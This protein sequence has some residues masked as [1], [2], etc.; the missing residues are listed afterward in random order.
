MKSSSTNVKYSVIIGY[1]LVV[2]VMIIGIV[3][4]YRNLV[5]FSEKKI[6]DEDLSE[7]LIVGNAISK[8]YDIESSQNLFNVSSAEKYFSKYDSILPLVK[9]NIDTL[10]HLAKTNSRIVKLD[11]IELL[12]ERKNKNLKEIV[13]LLDSIQKA[14]RITRSVENKIVPKELNTQIVDYLQSRN[15]NVE[16]DSVQTDTTVVYG[17]R[18]RFLDRVRDVFVARTDSTVMVDR[19]TTILPMTEFKLVVDTVVNM[20]RYSERV[21]LENQRKFQYILLQRQNAMAATNAQLTQQIDELLTG[22]EQEELAKSLQLVRDRDNAIS[23]S[24]QVVYL[25]ILLASLIVLIFGILYIADF[26]RSQRYRRQLEVSN[27]RISGLLKS[28]EQLILAVSHDIKAPMSS[29]IGYTELMQ[30]ELSSDKQKEYLKNMKNSGEH[31]LQ[32]TANLLDYHKLKSGTMIVQE[33][34]V[35]IY[36]LAESIINSFSPIAQ[37]KNIKYIT[38]NKLNKNLVGRIDSYIVRQIMNNIISNAIKY[39]FDGNVQVSVSDKRKNDTSW[40]VFSVKD[41]GIGIGKENQQVIFEEFRQLTESD[42]PVEGSGLGLAITKR[43]IEQIKGK[44]TLHSEKGRGSEFIVELPFKEED[45]SEPKEIEEQKSVDYDFQNVLVLLVDDD[46]VQLKMLS[47]MLRRKNAVVQTENNPENVEN[48]LFGH[49]FDLLFIDIQ[50]PQMNGFEL[51]KKIRQ[52]RDYAE[53]PIIALSAKSDVAK[54]D[55]NSVGF[56]DFLTK[57]FTSDE[58][59]ST[60]YNYVSDKIAV[61][62]SPKTNAAKVVGAKSLI[63]Y[64]EDDKKSSIEILD[65]FINDTT[66]SVQELATAFK[67]KEIETASQLVHKMLPLIDMMGH[68]K[69]VSHMRTVE[70]KEP[71]SA[72]IEEQ[73]LSSLKSYISD[74]EDLRDKLKLG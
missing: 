57:P 50:M 26:N 67:Q 56:S 25:V 22:I 70:K 3:S 41:T 27:N 48:A 51:V 37:Q 21:D 14:P 53:I 74:A 46:V 62:E 29:I 17:E 7:L 59:Y 69:I 52:L 31:I 44:L 68:T 54:S 58:L 49:H 45:K 39:T 32:L 16:V 64:V 43:L 2:I 15:I 24:Q 12:L 6:R 61:I 8:L 34:N 72:E 11:S 47:E 71:V 28:R 40:F 5:N 35:N 55:L 66:K 30:A 19:Q 33:A 60:V 13:V 1:I 36:D 10:K 63:Q 38:H 9:A 42:I 4:V 65:A 18:R 23:D 73:I 20:V